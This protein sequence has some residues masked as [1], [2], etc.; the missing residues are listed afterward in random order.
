MNHPTPS[1]TR[2]VR[3]S[4]AAVLARDAIASMADEVA[5]LADTVADYARS[6]SL[7]RIELAI[8][9]LRAGVLELGL[10]YKEAAAA[11]DG[12]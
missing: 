5:L 1:L 2:P 4:A 9:A 7:P 3:K 6:A 12:A 11:E 10:T 8:L